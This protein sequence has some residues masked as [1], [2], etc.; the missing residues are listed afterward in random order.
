MTTTI[1]LRDLLIR[2]FFIHTSFLRLRNYTTG[3]YT[4]YALQWE[5]VASTEIPV[6]RIKFHQD[7]IEAIMEMPLSE[8]IEKSITNPSQTSLYFADRG[9]NYPGDTLRIAIFNYLV[10]KFP[11]METSDA[12]LDIFGYLSDSSVNFQVTDEYIKISD[13]NFYNGDGFDIP[14]TPTSLLAYIQREASC[15]EKEQF[16]PSVAYEIDYVYKFCLSRVYDGTTFSLKNVPIQDMIT[17]AA[18]E[19]KYLL[20]YR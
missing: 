16:I 18:N 17:A 20:K 9:S 6:A 2:I 1:E 5:K 13:Q 19:T 10:S 8:L 12:L 3:Y 7:F 11:S 15:F 14:L 4:A